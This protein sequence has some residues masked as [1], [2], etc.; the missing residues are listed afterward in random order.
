MGL[1]KL[2]CRDWGK[3][4]FQL[5]F[6]PWQLGAVIMVVKCDDGGDDDDDDDGDAC[7]VFPFYLLTCPH[8]EIK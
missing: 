2:S 8:I 6:P 7:R 4:S 3:D 5:A 1:C